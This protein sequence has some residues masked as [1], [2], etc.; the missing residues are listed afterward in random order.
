[1]LTP[2]SFPICHRGAS[3]KLPT[4][5]LNESSNAHQK[6]KKIYKNLTWELADDICKSKY[7]PNIIQ[8]SSKYHP[9]IIQTSSKYHPNI[10]QWACVFAPSNPHPSSALN[11]IQKSTTHHP[12][13]IPTSSEYHPKI[14]QISSDHHPKYH[15]GSLCVCATESTPIFSALYLQ[16]P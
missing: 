14:I 15:P 13:I 10:T 3:F 4:L 5:A 6:V 8:T 11:S 9:N 7:H 2:G 1:M 16:P 12:N